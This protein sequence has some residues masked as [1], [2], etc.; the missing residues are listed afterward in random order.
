MVSHIKADFSASIV[1]FFVAL[2]LCLGIALASGAP[3]FSGVVAGIIGGIAVGYLSGSR[4]GV[5]GPA[6][7]L[8]VIVLEGIDKLGGFEVFLVS[9]VIAGL[10]QVAMGF[11]RLGFIAYFFPTSVITGMLS[12]IGILIILK[13]IPFVLG[14][15]AGHI[16][17]EQFDVAQGENTITILEHSF[18]SF[19]MGAVLISIVSIVLFIAWE[20][21]AKKYRFFHIISA[22]IGVVFAGIAMVM[23]YQNG[24]LGF[25][26]SPNQMVVLPIIHSWSDIATQIYLPN[27]TEALS[28]V[29][30][31]KVA[32]VIAILGS[33]ETLLSVEATDKL[34]PYRRVTPT[35]RELKA[36]GVGNFLSG[37][38]GGLPVTQVIVRSSA[39]ITFGAQSK[40]SAILHGFWLLIS[41]VTIGSLLNLIPLS[42]L[43]VI[44]IFVG[45]KLA[46]PK[47]FI[48]MYRL[49]L[50]QFVPF[51]ATIV[52]MIFTDLLTGVMSGVLI[53]IGFA[54]HHSYRNSYFMKDITSD[55]QGQKIH[56]I[57][58]SQEVSFF[59]KASII[60]KLEEIPNGAKV[61]ID[62]S[63]S[64]S[65]SYDV[66]EYIKEYMVHAPLKN[67][68]VET[69]NFNPR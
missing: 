18:T 24:V 43:S 6:A 56:H 23:L 35:N 11:A 26:L 54:L 38:I 50:E 5:S 52:I 57:M 65:V 42:S 44:L 20:A 21:L 29:M 13:Q 39:N 16:S 8:A 34:D 67:I 27:F 3:L 61:I 1:V 32:I 63:N 40:L 28:N 64:K 10:I 51:I 7:G 68:T 12:G 49:G 15:Q 19:T 48:Q 62:F 46:K 30:V 14:Y 60:S 9:I 55:E 33:L 22:P 45:Y 53:G 2:P 17:D 59:N 31:Y 66:A 25:T 4:L 37:L 41:V 69:I 47:L 36:Q 58:L